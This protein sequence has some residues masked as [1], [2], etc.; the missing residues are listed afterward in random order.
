MNYLNSTSSDMPVERLMHKGLLT[1][2]PNTPLY[3]AAERMAA[4]QCSSVLV[5]KNGVAVGIWTEHDSLRFNFNDPHSPHI[6]IGEVM[7]SPVSSVNMATSITD[8]AKR[9]NDEQRRHFLVT[10]DAGH[11]QG[12]ISQ[13]DV[14]LKQGLEMYLSLRTVNDTMDK[15]P[16]LLPGS[17]TLG[18]TAAFMLEQQQD[19]A[20]VSCGAGEFGIITE[21]DMVRFVACHPGETPLSKLASRPLATIEPKGSLLRA[22]DMLIDKRLRHLAVRDKDSQ[23][24]VGL[25][26]FRNI[27][28]G[29]EQRYNIELHHALATRDNAIQHSRLSLQLAEQVID[30]SLEGVMITNANSEITFVNPAFT[31]TTGYTAEEVLGGKPT[32]LSSG[33][34][35][36][37]FYE[38]MWQAL[39]DKGYWRGEIWNR[40]KNGQ[41]YLELLTITTIYDDNRNIT[42]FAA[43][44]TDITHIRENEDHIRKLA[45]YDALTQL[46][47][48]RL[49]EDRLE[50]AIRHAHRHKER[51]AVL[52]IDLDHFKQV[53]DSLGHA[54]GDD[55]LLDVSR[56]MAAR[57]REDDTLA[58][59]GGDE[60]IAVLPDITDSDEVT[61]VA[62]RL[63]EAIGAPFQL[64]NQH[65]RIGCSMGIS[66]YPD[67][68]SDTE[69]LL[70]QADAAMYRAKQEGRNTYR[71]YSTHLDAHE[72]RWL[73]METAL[74]NAIDNNDGLSLHY[75]PLF[76]S[77]LSPQLVS[78]EALARWQHPELGQVSP[79]EFIALAERS[80]LILPLSK[81]L[82][83]QV[84]AQLRYWLD[85]GLSPVPVA[86]N[87]SAQ[88][89][90]QHDLIAQIRALYDTFQLPAGLL[91]F[92]LTESILLDK[93]QPAIHVLTALRELGC[94]IAMDDF[95]TG[96]SSLSYLHQLPLTTLKVDRSF[97]Q[98]LD[99]NAGSE[100]ILAA[101]TGMAKGLKL[102]VVAEGVETQAQLEALRHYQVDLI[103][104]YLT[105]RPVTAADFTALYLA[106]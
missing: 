25:L 46:P 85:A 68:A 98:Q 18:Q 105:G 26:G 30:A 64:K 87:L 15:D 47:N 103:Q 75:Q 77:Q 99:E 49:L 35:D 13:T 80:G 92:E 3:E 1:C 50:Q 57:L 82:M 6:P 70:H 7:S 61:R 104:G 42:H 12:I 97:I 74:R 9:F 14:A 43:L 21:R 66:F 54:A 20:I 39:Q 16:L 72:H 37:L 60:F 2:A 101:I 86:V 62:R 106:P 4:R 28:E 67:D 32:V 5:I 22:R 19:A 73:A 40:H 96:Y 94:N 88:Q 10:D 90:W 24:I 51:F 71:L 48:R 36:Q 56:R 38:K 11:P 23:R 65:F 76:S 102:T 84:A 78:M 95:G 33:R 89:F 45:Y 91:S 59:L 31:H 41:L 44:F 81:L 93:Q 100:A 55:L 63:I 27:L 83:T 79:V 69:Q 8:V 53:N 29:A 17:L 58:R 52:F 34:H